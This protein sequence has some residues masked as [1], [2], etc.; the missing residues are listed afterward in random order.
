MNDNEH[1]LRFGEK[2]SYGLGDAASNL[3]WMSIIFFQLYYYTDVFGIS[4]EAAG[5]MIFITRLLDTANDPIMG[6]IG[7]RTSSRW[8]RFRPYLLFGAVPFAIAGTL[9]FASP[10][11]GEDGKLVYAYISY[12]LFLL[13]YTAVNIPYSSLMGVI[14]A[15]PSERTAVSTYRFTFAQAGGLLVQIST[16]HLVDL[17]GGGNEALGFRATMALYGALAAVFFLI[18]FYGTRERVEPPAAQQSINPRKELLDLLKNIPLPLFSLVSLIYVVNRFSL[19]ALAVMAALFAATFF[20]IRYQVRLPRDRVSN[21]VQDLKYLVTNVP[22]LILSVI[23]VL[24]LLWVSMKNGVTVYYFKYFIEGGLTL[25][26]LGELSNSTVTSIFMGAGTVSVIIGTMCT[27]LL[28]DLFDSKVRL[29]IFLMLFNGV[30]IMFVYFLTPGD[31]Y[32]IFAL[33]LLGSFLG[34][35]P[36]VIIFS[37]Y[38]DTADYSEW[39]NGRRATGLIFSAA[40]FSQKMGWTI[41]PAFAGL[42]LGYYGFE[43]N[44]A[45]NEQTLHGL[46][47]LIAVYPGIIAFA[48]GLIMFFYPLNK[49]KMEQIEND[50]AERK[51]AA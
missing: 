45:Q 41:G 13:A 5:V 10:E 29:F 32:L 7:D 19:T 21:T 40:G 50:L 42:L 48:S 6:M 15:N 26:L 18:T 36:I 11:L 33:H 35:P 22:W 38:A 12:S 28:V 30:S 31:L 43:A 24:T 2:L 1:K 4:P 17:F 25:P 20:Y 16:L 51:A 14:S 47:M 44:M 34:G 27:R 23:G 46:R 9:V 3:F 39:K 37:M 8:G 49:G